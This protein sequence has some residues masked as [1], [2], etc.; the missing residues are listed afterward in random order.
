MLW[1][2]RNLFWAIFGLIGLL[3]VVFGSMYLWSG[4]GANTEVD[5]E[6]TSAKQTLER[7][8]RANPSPSETNIEVAAA[9]FKRLRAIATRQEAYF[10]EI[11]YARVQGVEFVT[12]LNSNIFS[13]QQLAKKHNV[14]LTDNDRF[15]FSFE[16][17]MNKAKF[18]EGT[19]P[20]LAEE[21][22][23][24]YLIVSQ[25]FE[26]NISRLTSV[27][28]ARTRDDAENS[29]YCH[30]L[31]RLEDPEL[32][33]VVCPYEVTFYAFSSE[34]GEVFEKLCKAQQFMA[35]KLVAFEHDTKL[36]TRPGVP[37]SAPGAP[38]PRRVNPRPGG[39]RAPAPAGIMPP[40]P[41]PPPGGGGGPGPGGEPAN[42]LKE[43]D[44]KV[45]LLLEVMK[46]KPATN[47][48]GTN[49]K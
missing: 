44:C 17:Q 3:L 15:A 49:T 31:P 38:P 8:I 13:L 22:S 16:E 12:I 9:G 42:E 35:V 33:V 19:F 36:A 5:G 7:L 10:T 39:P 24:V 14:L 23:E 20:T 32:G 4:M 18:A 2:R 28:R 21:L 48:P 37:P 30:R 46:R 34:I 29:A 47:A 11:P 26:A 27:R 1:L 6:L 41:P 43:R 25:L 45:T 40:P